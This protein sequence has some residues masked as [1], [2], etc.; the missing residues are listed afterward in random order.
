[1]KKLMILVL[2][3]GLASAAN[4]AFTIS[5]PSSMTVGEIAWVDIVNDGAGPV[6]GLNLYLCITTASNAHWVGGNNLYIPPALVGSPGNSYIGLMDVDGDTIADDV[7]NSNLSA[8]VVLNPGAGVQSDFEIQCDAPASAT[9]VLMDASLTVYDT[10]TITQI[11]EP[12][13]IALLGLGGLF[14]RRRK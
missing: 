2:V 3:L 14:L 4:A 10:A 6:G 7:W 11:P 1:M 5:A 9:I 12:M 8:A 13:T